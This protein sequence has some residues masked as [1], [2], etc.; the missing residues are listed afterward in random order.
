MQIVKLKKKGDLSVQKVSTVLLWVI[1]T[2]L[3][4]IGVGFLLKRFLT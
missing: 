1:F 4:L 2:V 3:A